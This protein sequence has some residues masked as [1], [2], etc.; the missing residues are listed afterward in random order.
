MRESSLPTTRWQGTTIAIGFAPF[1]APTARHALGRPIADASSPYEIVAPAGTV[2]SAVQT[3]RRNSV[4]PVATAIPS[5]RRELPGEEGVE[6]SDDVRGRLPVR[7]AKAALA[8]AVAEQAAHAGL[9]VGEVERSE[10]SIAV[11]D[12]EERAQR[13]G[14]AVDREIDGRALHAAETAVR[15]R[16]GEAVFGSAVRALPR[17]RTS[18]PR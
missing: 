15:H 10:A 13:R 5:D 9:E 16:R 1:A 12:E 8:M 11:P 17:S 2:R 7:Q 3:A 4:P 6:S 18:A 14:H